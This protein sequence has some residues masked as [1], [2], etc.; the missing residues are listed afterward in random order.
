MRDSALYRSLPCSNLSSTSVSKWS[1]NGRYMLFFPKFGH[2]ISWGILPHFWRPAFLGVD[3]T[4]ST[5][6]AMS[7]AFSYK[8]SHTVS[9][10]RSF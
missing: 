3:G 7:T 5:A 8:A 1:T 4:T 10:A 2:I 9:S 6:D